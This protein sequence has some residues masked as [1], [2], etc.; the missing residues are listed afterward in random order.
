MESVLYL[1][2]K[3]RNK[4]YL[5][6]C[7]YNKDEQN[8]MIDNYMKC[9]HSKNLRDIHLNDYIANIGLSIKDGSFREEHEW[10]IISDVIVPIFNPTNIRY[11][12]EWKNKISDFRITPYMAIDLKDDNGNL[13][14]CEIWVGPF[15]NVKSAKKLANDILKDLGI[16]NCTVK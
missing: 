7:I 12:Y 14:I 3:G 10:R 6:R 11:G 16:K 9:L 5:K 8:K 4:L 13:P 2:S 15:G 1:R